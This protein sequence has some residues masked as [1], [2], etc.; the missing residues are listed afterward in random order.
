[1]IC[2]KIQQLQR[3][4]PI[5]PEFKIIHQFLTNNSLAELPPQRYDL[6]RDIYAIINEYPTQSA[7]QLR[8][9]AHRKYL[10]IQYLIWGEE[11][12]GYS[13]GDNFQCIEPY[14][15]EKDIAFFQGKGYELPLGNDYFVILF[16]GEYHKPGIM[17]NESS[18]VRKV[19]IKVLLS[20]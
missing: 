19:V 2:D 14:N 11:K 1:M 12:I 16:P 8:W 6:T 4:K 9:E 13:A 17:I 18:I 3:Y 20:I 7:D 10:D 5:F 15:E